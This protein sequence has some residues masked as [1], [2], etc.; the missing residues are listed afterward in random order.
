MNGMKRL[1][2]IQD[3]I[4]CLPWLLIPVLRSHS[5]YLT[6]VSLT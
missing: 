2:A 5:G 3:A 4:A 1:Q 6:N